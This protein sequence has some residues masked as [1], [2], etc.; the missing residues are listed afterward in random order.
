M[1][2]WPIHKKW[3]SKLGIPSEISDYVLRAVDSKGS[4][5]KKIPMPED[6]KQYTEDK[7]LQWSK[8]K[9]FAIADLK[10][11]LQDG[12][13]NKLIQTEYLK[14]FINKGTDYVKA[15][16]LHFILD[17]LNHPSIQECLKIPGENMTSYVDKY[18]NN[19]AV[20]LP[21]TDEY[22]LFVMDFLK[23]HS[24]DVTKDLDI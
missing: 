7:K 8:G 6:F 19:K 22:L 2:K 23:S 9:N 20:S 21:E 11:N 13:Q 12:A 4:S 10:E 24:Q 15:Y 18:K 1:A 14:F 5:D 16:Y 3:D 17:Y